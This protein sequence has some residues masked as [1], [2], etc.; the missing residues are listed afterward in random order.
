[1]SNFSG[2]QWYAIDPVD[3]W[4]FRDGKP[5]NRGEDQGDSRSLFPPLPTATVGTIR[6]ALA[7]ENGWDGRSNWKDV[8]V[9]SL[10]GKTFGDVIG[11][12]HSQT[13]QLSFAG[14]LVCRN[15]LPLFTMPRHV[16]GHKTVREDRENGIQSGEGCFAKE[17]KPE[18]FLAPIPNDTT[19]SDLGR[20]LL[21]APKNRS[22]HGQK[23]PE[24]AGDFFITQAG[25]LKVVE[26]SL[27]SETDCIDANDLLVM[28][29]RVG[30]ARNL[31]QRSVVDGMLYSPHYV[32]P[33]D[34]GARTGLMVGVD[35]APWDLPKLIAFGGEA[36]MSGTEKVAPLDLTVNNAKLTQHIALVL[37][38][39][40]LFGKPWWGA[41]PGEN[42]IQLDPQLSGRIES[43][44][45]DRPQR[46]GG[47]NSIDSVPFAK[48][49]AVAAGSV[50]WIE[51]TGQGLLP[52]TLIR[53]G[54][55]QH[56]GFG[57]AVVV[58]AP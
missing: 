31:V 15:N 4:F 14:P 9:P 2:Y 38:T 21:P 26:G 55:E 17:F 7:I 53:I 27:P 45:M 56:L 22:A 18:D 10:P 40:A 8:A 57:L 3:A 6:Y 41:G 50:W 28:E 19:E 16:L 54:Q 42:A 51:L 5:F 37:L 52:G 20:L 25:M 24:S 1:M 46:I 34:R 12:S 11:P 48:R 33:R 13:G 47:W 44:A 36:R 23:A 30:I 32:R 43:V 35:G 58:A 39:P 29:S 49:P